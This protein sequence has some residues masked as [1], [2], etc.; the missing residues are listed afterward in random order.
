M[1]SP[2]YSP[3][4]LEEFFQTPKALLTEAQYSGLKTFLKTKKRSGFGQ[5]MEELKKQ[6]MF[7]SL[8]VTS[9]DFIDIETGIEIQKHIVFAKVKSFSKIN[10]QQKCAEFG[11]KMIPYD[12]SNYPE[13]INKIKEN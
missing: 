5:F 9:V 4:E 6:K 11:M 2:N 12:G 10:T 7:Q 13:L 1:K 3:R 8:N